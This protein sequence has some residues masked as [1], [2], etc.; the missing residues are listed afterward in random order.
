MDIKHYKQKNQ[1]NHDYTQT[2]YNTIIKKEPNLMLDFFDKNAR[3]MTNIKLTHTNPKKK[4]SE[5]F[6]SECPVYGSCN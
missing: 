3:C 1:W 5:L 2:P 4:N 6:D